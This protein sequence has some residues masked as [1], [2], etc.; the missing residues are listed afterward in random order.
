MPGPQK[1]EGDGRSPA[2]VF[3]LGRGFGFAP[4]SEASWLKLPYLPVVEGIE[5]VDD[6]ASTVYNQNRR[7][8]A[9]ADAG[10]EQL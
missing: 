6:S 3:P 9:G 1:A 8:P 10:L 7:S 2:G 5:C 4:A